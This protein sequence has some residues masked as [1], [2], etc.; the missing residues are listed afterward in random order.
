M[1]TGLQKLGTVGS[2]TPASSCTTAA[3]VRFPPAHP[4]PSRLHTHT[5][6]AGW[7]LDKLADAAPKDARDASD[8]DSDAD[9]PFACV[10]CR[11]PFTDPVAT[12]CGHYFCAACAIKR[13]ARTP[14]CAACLA[15]TGGIFNRADRVLE[16][17]RKVKA[18]ADGE[19]GAEDAEAPAGGV[20][21]EGLAAPAE[22][23][24]EKD[25]DSES[26]DED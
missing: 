21:I 25:S 3:P 23:V 20:Q 17:L 12:R 1:L 2:A 14:K 13:F 19:D 7:Q 9:V 6:L 22:R 5:D 16:K 26:E 8:S 15:P 18:K 10:I 4:P 11:K 24:G